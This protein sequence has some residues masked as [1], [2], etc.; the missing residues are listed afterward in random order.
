VELPPCAALPLVP[1][2]PAPVCCC[3]SLLLQLATHPR[4]DRRAPKKESERI[5]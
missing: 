5:V 1:P 3:G 4:I 2:A